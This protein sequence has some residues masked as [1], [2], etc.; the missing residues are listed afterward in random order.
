[1]NRIRTK[2]KQEITILS[3]VC[4]N[5]KYIFDQQEMLLQNNTTVQPILKTSVR[6]VVSLQHS[7]FIAK[8]V[9]RKNANN[10]PIDGTYKIP[11]LCSI[12][13]SGANYAFELIAEIGIESYIEG[14]KLGDIQHNLKQQ[15]ANLDIPL[16]SMFDQQR[17][18]LFY[19]GALHHQSAEKIKSYL[20]RREEAITWLL[21][22][23]LEVGT[24]VFF[25]IK[26]A[27]SGFMLDCWKIPTENQEDISRCLKQGSLMYGEPEMLLHDLSSKINN[28]C[29]ATF[30]DKPHKVC[31]FHFTRDV[32]DG[33]YETP[34]DLLS[35]RLK[36][37]KLKIQLSEQRK[38]Q[39]AWIRKA[40]N[41]KNVS[42][43]IRDLL[44][45]PSVSG[46][47]NKSFVREIY[48]AINDWILDYAS[49]G[50]RQGFPFD[51]YLLYF[52][53]RIRKASQIANELISEVLSSDAMPNVFINFNN[54]LKEY[55]GGADKLPYS[56]IS[57][58]YDS[59][60]SF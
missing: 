14:D 54:I 44:N 39:T 19:F 49:E 15:D 2:A 12:V 3:Q 33:L 55:L 4:S 31:A 34:Q 26:E 30:K 24:P 53:R 17:K 47:N 13:P 9:I 40:I 1:M 32:G 16:S 60:F 35:T 18:F 20:Q 51:P 29:E 25:G 28:A 37:L 22:G 21:D 48:L 46:I 36:K 10:R 5:V 38:G 52:Q 11:S 7:R 45:D 41:Q 56:F 27:I 42:L 6:K 43:I 8:S 50:N 59:L 58:Q 23:T 57:I